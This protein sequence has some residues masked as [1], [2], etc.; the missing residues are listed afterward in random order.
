MS[1]SQKRIFALLLFMAAA[2]F[3][4]FALPNAVASKNLAMVQ[5][6]QPDE[7]A[8]LPYVFQMI[9]P[10]PSLNLAL[11]H[12]VFYEYYYY[13]FPFFASSALL[14]LPLQWLGRLGDTSLVMLI[15]RQFVS[16][17]PMLAALLLLVY[18]QDGF[19]SY[20]SPVL[21]AF[22]LSVPAVVENNSW[23][24]PDGITF[25]LVVL[26]ILFLKRD[27]LRFGRN[28]LLAAVLSGVATA[29]KLVGVYFFLAVGLT[30]LLGLVLRK[31]SWK[32]LV[33][34]AF[35][36][37]LAMGL[38]YLVANP[39]LLSHWARTAYIYILNK[40]GGLLE[41]G[42]GVVYLKGLAVSWP[43]IH[44]SYGELA[45]LLIAL[46][47][48]I[49]GAWRGPQRLLHGLILAW[50]VPVSVTVFFLT[51]FKFQYWMPV[52]LPLFS[53]LV[54][55]LPEKGSTNRTGHLAQIARIAAL[56]ALFAQ[57]VLFLNADYHTFETRMHRADN[58][59]SI[60]FYDQVLAAL[61]PLPNSKLHVYYDYRMYVPGKAGWV[62][63]TNF[64]L[65]EYNYI[66]KKNF[67]VLLLQQ[68]RIR[69]Y[70]NPNA[71]GID[72]ALFARNQQFYR[73]AD[74]ATITGY[75]LIYRD[76]FGLIFVRDELY[77]KYYS[78]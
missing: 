8:P 20:R 37:I 28:F 35:A 10:A 43:L 71:V 57:F 68:Q 46:G 65:L 19:R 73:D 66:H 1:L 76:K 77:Q 54:L 27:N 55:L 14:V 50:F 61:K 26:T 33:G 59:T 5:I 42:Y 44:E 6:F 16:V 4:I 3:I 74:N 38:A 64:D 52:A 53:S 69:D 29:T 15:L 12:F 62:T 22:L 34:M 13:G 17:L 78:K 48:T 18:M 51:H 40:Q 56:L 11:R 45:F 9:A 75:H 60:K 30:L 36:F 70:L 47:A 32:K 21:F 24:H 63:E 67:D 72:P 25:L 49:W 2:A 39:F 41:N 31:A 58:N 7:A 23:Y